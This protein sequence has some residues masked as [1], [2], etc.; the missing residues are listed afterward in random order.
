MKT[1]P[2]RTSRLSLVALLVASTLCTISARAADGDEAAVRKANAKFYTALNAMFTGKAEPMLAIWSH[3]DDV[4]YMGPGGGVLVGWKSISA[5]W[6]KQADMKLGGKVKAVGLHVVIGDSLAVVQDTEVGKNTHVTGG[7]G[8]V[9][10]RATNVYRKEDGAW[11][12][13]SH[14]TDLLPYLKP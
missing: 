10:I 5:A 3:A 11:K 6:Q 4:T 8:D 1:S 12:M 14:H 13:I 9:S 7:K 2:S